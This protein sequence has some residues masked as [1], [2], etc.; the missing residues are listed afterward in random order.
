MLVLRRRAG[1]A[2]L[3]GEDVEITVVETGPQRVVLGIRAPGDV[4]VMRKEILLAEEENRR[5]ASASMQDMLRL[6]GQI[7][8]L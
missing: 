4:R 2:I 3:V 7:R 5:A 6:A 1:E 8:G